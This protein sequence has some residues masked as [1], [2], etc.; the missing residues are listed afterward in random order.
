MLTPLNITLIVTATITALIAGLFYSWSISVTPGL[1]R[2]PDASYVSAFQA[3]NRAILNPM[4]LTC[5]LGA[6]VLLPLSTYL[7]YTPAPSARFWLLLAASVLYL[8]GVL[9]VTMAGNVPMNEAL[10]KFDVQHASAEAIAQVRK[11]FENRWN[12]LNTI[13]TIASTLSVVLVVMACLSHY[14]EQG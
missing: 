5:F 9:G 3:C 14:K 8:A 13:R 11:Q 4:F 10:D 2:L 6:A 1:G 12:N 7:H